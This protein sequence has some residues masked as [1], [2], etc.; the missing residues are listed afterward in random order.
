MAQKILVIDD[1]LFIR[2]LYVEI[3]KK[4]GFG[5]D[6][7][8]DGVE[9]LEKLKKGSYSI[10]LLDMTMPKLDGLGLLSALSGDPAISENGPIVLLTNSS[11]DEAVRKGLQK[12]AKSY[13][14]KADMN[15]S[16]LVS[17]IKKILQKQ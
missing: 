5:V 12:G 15:P 9:G 8:E 10:I 7:A 3:L 17:N 13:L 16:E 6:S 14:V 1:D 11:D 2:E 4:A